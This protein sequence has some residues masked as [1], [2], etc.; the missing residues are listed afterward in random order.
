MLVSMETSMITV[1]KLV[2][3]V[4]VPPLLYLLLL[5]LLP[6][7]RADDFKLIKITCQAA[8]C[9]EKNNLIINIL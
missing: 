5:L 1:H 9:H 4:L 2:L 6:A 8:Q 3:I 7:L